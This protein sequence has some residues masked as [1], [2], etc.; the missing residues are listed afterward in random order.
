MADGS[1]KQPGNAN[2][3]SWAV[4]VVGVVAA[5]LVT[6]GIVVAGSDYGARAAGYSVFFWCA[7][8]AFGIQWVM[9]I[10]AWSTHSEAYFDLTGSI[11][12]I[13]VILM[14]LVMT[15][16]YDLGSLVLAGLVVIWAARLGP[17]LFLRIRK[18]GEDRRF[19]SIRHSFPTFFMTWT[20]QG[21]WVFLTLCCALAALTGAAPVA[22]GSL[23]WLG[24][25]MWLAGFTIEVVAD[26]QKTK[27]RSDPANA[28][29]FITTGLWAWS[30]HPNYFGEIV[31][32]SGVAVMAF[33]S[34]QGNQ[35]YTL[36]SPIFVVVLLVFISGVRM[37]ENRADKR[38]GNEEAY[39]AYKKHTPMLMLWPPR[40]AS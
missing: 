33:S 28:E 3:S 19:K 26:N 40:K 32:W 4:A 35:I 29:R 22:L 14:G 37:L 24:L 39:I 21:T 31:L 16:R 7:V 10:H 5:L 12:H 20:L 2:A 15:G 27:F 30:R 9:F 8:V 6:W 38:W 18:A 23:F 11:T 36:I 17:F 1:G 13:L 25:L 34:L